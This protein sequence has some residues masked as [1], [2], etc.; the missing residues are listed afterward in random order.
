[1][2]L[3]LEEISTWP[4]PNYVDPVTRG[5]GLIIMHLVLYPIIF[6]LIALRTY[7]RLRISQSFGLDDMF[8]LLAMACPKFCCNGSFE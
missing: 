2:Y 7:T 1:M 5:P 8:I 4:T 6:G 3:S